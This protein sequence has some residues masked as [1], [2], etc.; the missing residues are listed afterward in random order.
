MKK[1]LNCYVSGR[2][3][4]VC[5]RMSTSQQAKILGLTGWVRN[6]EDGRVEVF[7]SGEE[8]LLAQLEQ[9]LTYGPE[10]AQVINIEYNDVEYQEFPDFSIR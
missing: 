5:F 2:V 3:Q 8:S 7:A 1:S 9:W 6:L 10:M 4:G